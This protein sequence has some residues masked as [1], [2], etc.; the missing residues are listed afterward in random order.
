MKF[1]DNPSVSTEKRSLSESYQWGEFERFRSF[2]FKKA[3]RF[4]IIYHNFNDYIEEIHRM[5]QKHLQSESGVD[6]SNGKRKRVNFE[7]AYDDDDELAKVPL[8][9]KYQNYF[10]VFFMNLYIMKII[11]FNLL[12]IVIIF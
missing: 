5:Q 11:L 4:D 8:T 2:N 1:S 3:D 12:K 10:L 9:E 6:S 7:Q